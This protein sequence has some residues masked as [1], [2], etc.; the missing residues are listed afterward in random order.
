MKDRRKQLQARPGVAGNISL[1]ARDLHL[2]SNASP[3]VGWPRAATQQIVWAGLRRGHIRYQ[4]AGYAA[5]ED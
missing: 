3:E 1:S 2:R 4:L 5:Q